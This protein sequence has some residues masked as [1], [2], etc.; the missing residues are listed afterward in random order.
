MA[1]MRWSAQGGETPPWSA[2]EANGEKGIET[3]ETF[4]SSSM[5]GSM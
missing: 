4:L 5:S 3:I 1:A 2:A